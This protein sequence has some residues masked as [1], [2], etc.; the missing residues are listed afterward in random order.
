MMKRKDDVVRQ[1]TG[2]IAMLFK[3]NNVTW[4]KGTGRFEGVEGDLKVV[5]VD[6]AEGKRT[7]TAPRVLI[8][9]G[10]EAT[11]LPFLPFD[12]KRVLSS[13]EALSIPEIPKHLVIIGGGVIGVEMGSVWSRLGAKV[14][15]IEFSDRICTGF[16]LQAAKEL[17]KSLVKQGIEFR[18][19]TKCLG[20]TLSGNT[21][22]V[23]V[24]NRAD[25]SKSK[26]ECDYVLVATGRRPYTGQQRF[27]LPSQSDS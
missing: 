14:T 21:M 4:A 25:N 15:V 17:Q 11:P 16:D 10:S 13:T 1:L 18:L 12:G 27:C 19:S 8:A 7:L 22:L 26:I 24:E 23:E 3:K 2:G 6:G 20:A 9:T 5:S